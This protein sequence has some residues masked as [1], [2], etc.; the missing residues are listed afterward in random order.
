MSRR[1]TELS[2]CE[3]SEEDLEFIR[4]ELAWLADWIRKRYP[5]LSFADIRSFLREMIPVS[6]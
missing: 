4:D 1:L 5:K 2:E 6:V 3:F